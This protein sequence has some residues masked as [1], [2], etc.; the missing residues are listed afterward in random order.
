M[1]ETILAVR[2]VAS[3]FGRRIYKP[4]AIGYGIVAS[5]IVGILIWLLTMSAWWLLLAVPLFIITIAATILMIIAGI[6]IKSV[7]PTQTKQQRADVSGFVDGLQRLSEVTQTPKFILL[8]RIVKDVV[9]PTQK[10]FIQSVMADSV[11]V[12]ADFQS[13]IRSFKK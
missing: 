11:S 6:I 9:M 7:S 5:V 13:L 3:E 8:F 2:A 12:K 10:S 1:N 4:V